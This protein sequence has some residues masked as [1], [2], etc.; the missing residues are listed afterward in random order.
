M[1]QSKVDHEQAKKN[2]IALELESDDEFDFKPITKGLGFHQSV[3][4]TTPARTTS[5]GVMNRSLSSARP[6]GTQKI[7][8]VPSLNSTPTQ[9]LSSASSLPQELKAFYETP[10]ATQTESAAIRQKA[11]TQNLEVETR[12]PTAGSIIQ[13]AA[14]LIDLVVIAIFVL[15]TMAALFYTLEIDFSVWKEVITRSRNYVVPLSLFS[16]YY[17]LYFGVWDLVGGLGKTLMGIKVVS[18][19][20][21]EKL[22]FLKTSLR[23]V[24]SLLSL[25]VFG[26]PHIVDFQG[27][28]S[29]TEVVS[30]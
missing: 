17:I 14:W 16:I 22:S 25:A 30:E 11:A 6:Q 18:R 19:V 26:L 24:I 5:A 21:G 4:K 1:N 28:L 9:S 12:T 10:A 13:L 15:A 23:A 20:K 29:D 27:K 7:P 8:Q 2:P 3:K